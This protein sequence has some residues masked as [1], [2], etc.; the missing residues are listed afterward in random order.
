MSI[1]DTI[2]KRRTLKILSS[3]P[4]PINNDINIIE[5]EIKNLLHLAGSAPFHYPA[6]KTALE[7]HYLTSI[8]PWRF[9]VLNEVECRKLAQYM[10]QNHVDGGKIL[11]MLHTAT[12]LIQVTWIPEISTN[13]E[14]E[15]SL[16]NME[17]IAATGAAIQNL[18]LSATAINYENYWSS[19]G[20]LRE[21][22]FKELLNI[23]TNEILLGS[24]FLFK[25]IENS[26]TQ[27]VT[28]AWR[29]QQGAIETYAK[30]V[31]VDF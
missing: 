6:N 25:N 7:N 3:L 9:Y 14:P 27:Q 31:S 5:N 17:H 20:V 22:S 12:A 30:F 15:M 2:L 18:L 19:G 10:V 23:P 28:G 1:Q 8:A 26:N 21:S 16:K 11:Q 4:L 24:V 29:G 13:N